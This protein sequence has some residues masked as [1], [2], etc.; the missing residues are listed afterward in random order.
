MRNR[1]RSSF[2]SASSTPS[3]PI[4]IDRKES[5]S[6][7]NVTSDGCETGPAD[8][9]GSNDPNNQPKDY[10]KLYEQLL[11]EFEAYK[12]EVGRKEQEWNR[13][14]RQMQRKLGELEEELKQVET[15]KQDN[16]R[17]KEENGALIRVI[18]K[19]SKGS[20]NWFC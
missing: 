1:P 10:K 17:L 3:D 19:L 20:S 16:L 11:V 6:S 12:Q 5:L 4:S 7:G 9:I 18:S 8:C 2:D 14:K 15:L 13:E